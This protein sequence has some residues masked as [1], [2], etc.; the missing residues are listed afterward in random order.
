MKERG[1]DLLLLLFSLVLTLAP[2]VFAEPRFRW[3][4]YGY[5]F[6]VLLT[7]WYLTQ[8]REQDEEAEQGTRR[9]I[10]WVYASVKNESSGKDERGEED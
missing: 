1:R 7:H 10:G 2:V 3:Y 9:L 6:E 5:S 8:Q 4:G